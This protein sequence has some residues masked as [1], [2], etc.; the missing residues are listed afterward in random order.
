[1]L[2]YL[3]TDIPEESVFGSIEDMVESHSKVNYT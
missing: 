3:V 1:M 2:T